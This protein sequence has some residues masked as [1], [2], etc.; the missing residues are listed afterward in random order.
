MLDTNSLQSTSPL[1]TQIWDGT[2]QSAFDSTN[3]QANQGMMP[4]PSDITM[5]SNVV[6]STISAESDVLVPSSSIAL[7]TSPSI[8][9]DLGQTLENYFAQPNW[10][11]IQLP[12]L[13]L[14]YVVSAESI[15]NQNASFD[16]LTG[17]ITISD[18]FLDQH[19][20]EPGELANLVLSVLSPENIL[21]QLSILAEAD[22]SL[23]SALDLEFRLKG[24]IFSQKHLD[25]Q[26]HRDGNKGC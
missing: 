22:A 1:T 25:S 19:A 7:P 24:S 23:P 8:E 21:S 15:G 4:I 3:P 12:E 6:E 5:Q 13:P 11:S 14:I 9:F 17:A 16:P 10:Q 2:P 18:A 20:N 26:K